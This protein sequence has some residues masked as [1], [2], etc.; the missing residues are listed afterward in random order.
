MNNVLFTSGFVQE[1]RKK[2]IEMETQ[3]K[4][5][6]TRTRAIN[7]LTRIVTMT[8][9]NIKLLPMDSKF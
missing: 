7:Q 8:K 5:R 2:K 4:K 1:Y 3:K 9:I 6:W